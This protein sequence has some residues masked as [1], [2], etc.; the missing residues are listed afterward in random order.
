MWDIHE[1]F[2]EVQKEY[3]DIKLLHF[4]STDSYFIVTRDKQIRNMADLKGLKLRVPGGRAADTIKALGGIPVAVRMPELYVALE[5]GVLDGAPIPG[6]AYMGQ[7]PQNKLKYSIMAVHLWIVPFW[8]GL[9]KRT[10]EKLSKEDQDAIMSVSGADGSA[11][12]GKASFDDAK[13]ATMKRMKELNVNI[14]FAPPEERARWAAVTKPIHEK[15]INEL[16]AKGLPGRKVY[17]EI[18]RLLEKYS[19]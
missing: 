15:Y 2:P 3:S 5:K 17:N 1:K 16:E 7:V 14:T 12:C 9:N 19:K 6:E 11:A 10:W 4:G 18:N 8:I 13:V